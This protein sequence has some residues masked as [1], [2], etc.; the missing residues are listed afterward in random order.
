[1]SR[2]RL[3]ARFHDIPLRVLGDSKGEAMLPIRL[4]FLACIPDQGIV[5]HRSGRR[6]D[7]HG[8]PVSTPN[9]DE[10][11]TPLN[12]ESDTLLQL[13]NRQPPYPATADEQRDHPV[14]GQ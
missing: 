10:G 12:H 5:V 9:T 1:M 11:F 7:R 14:S 4:T 6:G 2:R 3:A 13:K 8:R